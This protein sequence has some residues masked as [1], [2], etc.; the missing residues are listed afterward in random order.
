LI[1]ITNAKFE[2]LEQIYHIERESFENPYPISLLNAYLYLSPNL[3]LVAKDRNEVVGYVIGIIQYNVRGHI[4]SIAVKKSER[5]KGIGRLLLT[6]LERRFK[7]YNCKYSYLEVNIDNK[8]AINFY[9]KM[10]YFIVKLQKNYYGRG[11]HAFVML[12]D[13]LM[14]NLE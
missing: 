13:L 12:K 2:D 3:Y 4:V 7:I 5:R 1:E 14:R 6:E 11:K 9:R 10:G 8:D